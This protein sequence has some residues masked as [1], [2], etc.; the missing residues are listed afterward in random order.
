[1]TDKEFGKKSQEEVSNE[2]G[3]LQL[4]SALQDMQQK[5]LEINPDTFSAYF[6]REY[7]LPLNAT[8]AAHFLNG[9]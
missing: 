9:R 5:G 1:M 7:E 4:E 6:Q 2:W 8:E 3:K